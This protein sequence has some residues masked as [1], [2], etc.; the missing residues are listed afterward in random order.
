MVLG[1]YQTARLR[2][3]SSVYN[4]MGMVF[5]TRRTWVDPEDLQMIF[6]DDEY[7]RLPDDGQAM[8]GDVVVYRDTEGAVVH[9]GLVSQVIPN[10]REGTREI[11]VLSQWGADGEYFHRTDDVHP[12]LG[13]PTDYWSD[14]K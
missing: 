4:C 5:A 3:L 6:E 11:V 14:R 7:R 10:L 8:P 12:S 13:S 1:L 2:S 9:I